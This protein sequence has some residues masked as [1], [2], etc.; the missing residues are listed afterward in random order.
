MTLV[1]QSSL[2]EAYIQWRRRTFKQIHCHKCQL[3]NWQTQHYDPPWQTASTKPRLLGIDYPWNKSLPC[4]TT[5]SIR[6]VSDDCGP[7]SEH[8][9]GLEVSGWYSFNCVTAPEAEWARTCME[10]F[11]EKIKLW[12]WLLHLWGIQPEKIQ[13]LLLINTPRARERSA[14]V[15][16]LFSNFLKEFSKW[17]LAWWKV[18]RS[19]Q[20]KK[21]EKPV[22][23]K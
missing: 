18:Q 14:H 3:V 1:T 21:E 2:R 5:P 10:T 17:R 16:S 22:S 6:A 20:G 23:G 7:Q 13:Y 19:G 11:L 4:Q 9:K 15:F 8:S 12:L